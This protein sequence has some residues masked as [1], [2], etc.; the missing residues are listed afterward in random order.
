M[1]L[2]KIAIALCLLISA[3]YASFAQQGGSD[4]LP[5]WAN[6]QAKSEIIKFVDQV[7]DKGSPKFVRPKERIA[8]FDNDG[9]LWCEQPVVQIM[10]AFEEVKRQAAKHPEWKNAQPFKAVLEGD[11]VYF[12]KDYMSGAKS[13]LQITA[14]THSGMTTEEF[15][16]AVKRFFASSRHP[17][18]KVTYTKLVYQPMLELLAY[19]RAKGFKTYIVSGGGIHFMRTIAEE[20]YGVDPENVIGSHGKTAFEK[21]GESWELVKK[22]EIA[23]V[24]DKRGKPVAIDLHIGRKPIF[25]AGNVRSGGDIAMLTYC[26]TNKLPTLQILVNHDDPNREFQYSETNNASL[27]AARKNG[28]AVVSI[29]KDW[30]RVF[31]FGKQD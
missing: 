29:K 1:R 7:T 16:G 24:N 22:P 3:P 21:R 31:P 27:N 19:L 6:G 23:F 28:W 17:K 4:P 12:E 8:V 18:F 2:L 15:T 10:F 25:A 11:M 13:L 9:T 5:S 30:K 26:Q 14:V 20:T